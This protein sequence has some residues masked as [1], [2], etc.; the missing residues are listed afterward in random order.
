MSKRRLAHCYLTKFAVRIEVG[1]LVTDLLCILILFLSLKKSM[2]M[3][4]SFILKSLRISLNRYVADMKGLQKKKKM[5]I[6]TEA[7]EM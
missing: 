2:F 3:G 7:R 1:K 4:N 5:C 6:T